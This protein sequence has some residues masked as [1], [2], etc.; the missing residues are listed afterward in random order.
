MEKKEIRLVFNET[1]FTNVCKNG[2]MPYKD[3]LGTIDIRFNKNDIKTLCK[4]DMLVIDNDD[5]KILIILQDLGLDYIR[6]IV[7]RSPIFSDLAL[8]I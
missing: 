4:G 7:R 6:E 1:S 8:E 3:A 2:F 5:I